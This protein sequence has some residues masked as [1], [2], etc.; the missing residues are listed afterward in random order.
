MSA[1][2]LTV[3]DVAWPWPGRLVATPAG[4]VRIADVGSPSDPVLL[5]V[6]VGLGG[7]LW[8]N[9]VARLDDRFRCIVLD[10]PGTGGSLDAEVGL[11][12][13]AD[14]VA[15]VVETLGLR[16]VTLVCH[17]LGGPASIAACSRIGD[18]VVGLVAVNTF[19]WR[20]AGAGF[21]TM[22]AVMGGA[23]V[24]ESNALTGWFHAATST[25]FGVGRHWDRARRRAYRHGF[26]PRSRRTFH[27]YMADARRNDAVFEAATAAL[28]GPLR[29]LPLLTVFGERNDPLHFQPRWRALFPDAEQAVIPHG[30]H[31]PMCDAPETVADLIGEFHAKRVVTRSTAHG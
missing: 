6:H 17:D 2:R 11:N 15:A 8:R 31:F 4:D 28:T 20:P 13:A 9:T 30:Y 10:A 25:G 1:D 14:A 26:T 12:H 23:V 3:P 7:A 19:A 21:R 18:R 22:L 27:R 29:G 5:L 16:D 24:R